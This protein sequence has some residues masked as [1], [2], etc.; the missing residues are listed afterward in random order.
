[1]S[2]AGSN[3]RS[4]PSA[5]LLLRRQLMHLVFSLALL[6]ASLAVGMLGYSHIEHLSWRDAF[7]NA[8]MLLGGMGPIEQDLSEPGK[9]FAGAYAL[10]CGLVVIAVTGLLLAPGVHHVMHH[11]DWDDRE[12]PK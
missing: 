2:P 8:S 9:I 7:V 4:R 5:R 10:Y 12:K 6:A 3:R 11:V 1:M